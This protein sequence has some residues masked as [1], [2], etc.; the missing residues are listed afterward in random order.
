MDLLQQSNSVDK[1]YSRYSTQRRVDPPISVSG[2]SKRF[3]STFFVNTPTL[4]SPEYGTV[5]GSIINDLGSNTS[6][7]TNIFNKTHGFETK[8]KLKGVK[9][10]KVKKLPHISSVPRI[11]HLKSPTSRKLDTSDS[12]TSGMGGLYKDILSPNVGHIMRNLAKSNKEEKAE[13]PKAFITMQRESSM[14]AIF[15]KPARPSITRKLS[16]LQRKNSRLSMFLSSNT[17][18]EQY[19]KNKSEE[20]KRLSAAKIKVAFQ[21]LYDEIMTSGSVAL[22]EKF[23]KFVE[24]GNSSHLFFCEQCPHCRTKNND[25]Y[26]VKQK[27]ADVPESVLDH[28]FLDCMNINKAIATSDV[29]FL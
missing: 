7:E 14:Q 26:C 3:I 24:T 9:T 13:S 2:K 5:S 19:F 6:R 12:E 29:F 22:R 18:I 1:S 16:M 28:Y 8:S 4:V 25:I 15:E 27:I 23:Y 20:K 21:K 10:V 11:S 17:F